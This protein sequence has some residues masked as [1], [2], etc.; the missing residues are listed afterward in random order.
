[1]PSRFN[2][3]RKG[4][5]VGVVALL[6]LAAAGCGT[7][8]PDSA[9]TNSGQSGGTVN[10]SSNGGSSGGGPSAGS[11]GSVSG[12]TGG[13]AGAL[14]ASSSGGSTAAGGSAAGS[15]GGGSTAGGSTGSSGGSGGASGSS[16]AGNTASDVGVTAN[17]ITVGNI[18]AIGGPLG[19]EIF[20]P[21]LAGAT[22]YFDMLNS[23][24]GINGRKVNFIT[25]DDQE[26][27]NQD[28]A[29]AQKLITQDK[30]FA[31]VANDTDNETSASYTNSKGVPDVG[32]FCIGNACA[33]YPHVFGWFGEHYPRNGQVG[34]NGTEYS[35]IDTFKWYKDNL[36]V[37]NAADF[38]YSIPIS[39]QAGLF[40]AALLKAVG[41]NVVYYGGGSDQGENPA[42]PTY[43]TDVIQMRNDHVDIIVDAI[44]IGG[45]AKL[46]QSMDRFGFTVKAN[47]TT[48]QGMGQL[49][50]QTFSSPCRD[51]LYAGDSSVPY[52]DTSNP[53]VQAMRAA[54]KKYEPN[55]T[56]HQWVLDGWIAAKEFADGVKALGPDVTRAGLERWLNGLNESYT[57][58]GL[59]GPVGYEPWN[60][61]QPHPDCG[62][63][64]Q[65]QDSAGTFVTRK[66]LGCAPSSWISY[67]ASNTGGS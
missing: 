23:Q 1:M 7:H 15:S 53:G 42:A 10:A 30:I 9:F 18:T 54:M 58:G 19:P 17:S 38:F 55:V 40:E 3:I 22:A 31:F 11:A 34:Y 41:I 29:C 60:F 25:C 51:S 27:P 63:I 36:G 5:G 12:G 49:V 20:S 64:A 13:S 56:L 24:G 46:C 65:W 52:S 67:Q 43:D 37:K 26:N 47:I 50:G 61:S 21:S 57:A 39:R 4:T 8:L 62:S 33:Q 66:P 2:R 59:T 35:P 48:S 45:L 28:V 6:G 16:G 32:D 14:A 44:D